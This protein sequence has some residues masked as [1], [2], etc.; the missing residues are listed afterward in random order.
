MLTD[1]DRITV[2]RVSF[3]EEEWATLEH[4]TDIGYPPAEYI[5]DVVMRSLNRKKR[6]KKKSQTDR[7]EG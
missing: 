7:K 1:Y 4:N 3:S 5:H 6:A 2:V